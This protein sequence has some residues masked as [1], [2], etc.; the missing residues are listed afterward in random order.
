MAAP[1]HSMTSIAMAPTRWPSNKALL[2]TRESTARSP[3]LR[4]CGTTV[5]ESDGDRWL[6]GSPPFS[7][8]LALIGE[9]PAGAG[10]SQEFQ[11]S[12]PNELPCADHESRPATSVSPMSDLQLLADE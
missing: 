11:A 4:R 5:S 9:A 3:S 10:D 2:R 6:I 1:A 12:F 8:M 7:G